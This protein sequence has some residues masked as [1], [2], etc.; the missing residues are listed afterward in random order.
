MTYK[1]MFAKTTSKLICV[2]TGIKSVLRRSFRKY[3][4]PSVILRLLLAQEN[5]GEFFVETSGLSRIF[6]GV[7]APLKIT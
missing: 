6:S 7:K 2:S 5:L 4:K 1:T 3:P